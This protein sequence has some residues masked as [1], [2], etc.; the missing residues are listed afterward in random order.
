MFISTFSLFTPSLPLQVGVS[1]SFLQTEELT[2]G[3][4]TC[5]AKSPGFMDQR[6]TFKNS[7]GKAVEWNHHCFTGL[8]WQ[9]N[10][11]FHG[12]FFGEHRLSSVNLFAFISWLEYLWMAIRV[13]NCQ[14]RFL[15]PGVVKDCQSYSKV[16]KHI[17]KILQISRTLIQHDSTRENLHG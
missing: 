5:E 3:V 14:S 10:W 2:C 7:Y 4:R 8:S 17:S 13:P 9:P 12:N 16:V 6:N 11:R 1:Q 15:R